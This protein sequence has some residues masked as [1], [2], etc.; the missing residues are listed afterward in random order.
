MI[1]S[2]LVFSSSKRAPLCFALSLFSISTGRILSK[3]HP[4]HVSHLIKFLQWLTVFHKGRD[5]QLDPR[6]LTCIRV[7][8]GA[9]E[10][11]LEET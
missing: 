11:L 8:S 3:T 4:G 5:L 2:H 9:A 7:Q 6:T 10:V 1:A